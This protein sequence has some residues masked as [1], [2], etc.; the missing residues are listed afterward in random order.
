MGQRNLDRIAWEEWACRAPDVGQMRRL[1]WRVSACCIRCRVQLEV[2]LPILIRLRGPGLLLWGK[3]TR[4]RNV[5][6]FMGEA[7]FYGLP[8][9]QHAWNLLDAHWLERARSDRLK[10]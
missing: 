10:S 5:A 9:G 4:C 3:R 8:P 6:C 1:R 7:Y 2:S